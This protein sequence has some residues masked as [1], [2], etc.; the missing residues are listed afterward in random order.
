MKMGG[1]SQ[2]QDIKKKPHAMGKELSVFGDEFDA[3]TYRYS[4]WITK[5]TGTCI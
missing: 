2:R 5:F 4:V 3:E 1:L